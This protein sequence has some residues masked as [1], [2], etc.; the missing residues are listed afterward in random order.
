[1]AATKENNVRRRKKATKKTDPTSVSANKNS[2]ERSRKETVVDKE[3][4]LL[5]NLWN[6]S[7]GSP[8]FWISVAVMVPYSLYNL[9]LFLFLQH[10]EMISFATLNLVRPRPPVKISDPR[11]VLIVG[12]ISAGTSQ[13][14]H[15]LR[16]KLGLEIGHENSEASWSFVRDGTVSWFHGIRYIPRPLNGSFQSSVNQLCQNLHPN[17]GFHP[18]MFRAGKCSLRQKWEACWREECKDVLKSEWGC[19]LSGTCVTPYRNVL[20]QVRHPLR[21]IESLVTK[22]CIN[23]VEGDVQPAFLIFASALFP[24]HDFSKMSCI[25]A[26]GYYVDEYNSAIIKANV[27]ATYRVEEMTPCD[28]AKLAGFTNDSVVYAQNKKLISDAC[29]NESSEANK[30][31]KSKRN[32]YNKGQLS[33]DWD[34]LLG[35]KHGSRRKESDRDLLTRIKT[36]AHKLGYQ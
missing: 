11:Q 10:P 19:G 29:E 24:H 16:Q 9:Y 6:A 31:M 27:D 30:L 3:L 34:D 7:K 35:G 5:Q 14:S 1:M 12:S 15:D 18:F 23:G 17:M 20:H 33:L 2:S 26:A 8:M 21:T 22:F 25:E 13:V 4:S 32:L 28:I 36:L